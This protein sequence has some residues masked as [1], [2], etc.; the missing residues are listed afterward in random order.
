M[1]DGFWGNFWIVLAIFS[2][3]RGIW[4][5]AAIALALPISRSA[6]LVQWALDG[7]AEPGNAAYGVRV[8]MAISILYPHRKFWRSS[9]GPNFPRNFKR[10]KNGEDHPMAPI[11]TIFRPNE[12][13][14]CQLNFEKNLGRRKK[15]REGEK[16]E[17]LSR[18]VRKICPVHGFWDETK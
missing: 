4:Q 11:F 2:K 3:N 8:N 1:F 12:S 10:P 18:K 16:F 9:H 7:A 5:V 6:F 17:K 13:Q 14:C 15:F